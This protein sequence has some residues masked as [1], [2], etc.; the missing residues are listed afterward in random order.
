MGSSVPQELLIMIFRAFFDSWAF[1]PSARNERPIN[2]DKNLRLAAAPRETPGRP[3]P[4]PLP[5]SQR[6]AL[7]PP[8]SRS[9]SGLCLRRHHRQVAAGLPLTPVPDDFGDLSKDLLPDGTDFSTTED[10]RDY[11][12]RLLILMTEGR[13]SPRRASVMAY[14]TTQLLHTHVVAEKETDQS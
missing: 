13:V 10:L 2:C 8:R 6:S 11:L 14:V 1:V 3:R 4:L 7:H 5:L 12:L 9:K